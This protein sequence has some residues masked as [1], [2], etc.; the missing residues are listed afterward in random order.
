LKERLDA[1]LSISAED[2]TKWARELKL[3]HS[4]HRIR[5]DHKKLIVVSETPFGLIPL[6]NMGSGKN[7]VG[8]HLVTYFALAKWFVNQERPV[9]RFIIFSQIHQQLG[10]WMRFQKMKTGLLCGTYSS[11]YLKLQKN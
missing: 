5:L 1:Q 7:W 2:M 3:E 9:G 8:D 10:I 6:S 11:G 4:E